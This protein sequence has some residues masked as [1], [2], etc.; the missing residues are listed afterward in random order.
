MARLIVEKGHEKGLTI[1]LPARTTTVFGRDMTANVQIKDTMASRSHFKIE[2]R[3]DGLWL[4]DL[5]SMNGTLL[6][7]HPAKESRLNSGD[8]IR[9]GETTYSFLP[10]DA[11]TDPLIGQKL[12]GYKLIERVG[13]G[14]MGTVYKAEQIDL[15]R[16]V[17][18]K[19]IS[20]EHL[21]NPEFVE[22]FVHEA[23]AAAKLNH[24]NIVQVYD[25]KKT[26]EL[27]YFSME[28]VPGGSVQDLLNNKR[29][30]PIPETVRMILEAARG[31][32][33]AHK[34]EIIHRDV[35]PD[36]FM[37]GEGNSI[38]IGDL[39][40]AQRLGEK[41]SADNE[42][43]VIGTPHY[44]AP[45]Q[46][47]GRPADVR[48]DVYSLGSTMYRM[49]A[50]F[51]PFQ[52]PS[53]RELVNKKAREEATPLHAALGGIPESLGK[54]CGKMMARLP[55]E[56]TQ[57]MTEVIA[58]LEAWTRAVAGGSAAPPEAPPVHRKL[59]ISAV[60]LLAIV[61]VG[62]V[63]AAGAMLKKND[64][65]PSDTAPVGPEVED[66]KAA[67]AKFDRA[68]AAKDRLVDGKPDEFDGVIRLYE[69]IIAR[70]PGTNYAKDAERH[71]AEIKKR[72]LGLMA[73]RGLK[74]L[75]DLDLETWKG[76]L[77]SFQAGREDVAEAD[78]RMREFRAFAED[79][80]WQGTESALAA[81][82]RAAA[83]AGWIGE[84]EKRRGDY[85]KLKAKTDKLMS[86][87][88]YRDAWEACNEYIADIAA[89]PASAKDR[90]TTLL[91]DLPARRLQQQVVEQASKHYDDAAA[92]AAEL[93]AKG[94]Y[95][96]AI[97]AL[98][99]SVRNSL[100]D[101]V[102]RAAKLSKEIHQRWSDANLKAE[103]H[104]KS[105]QRKLAD[106]DRRDFDAAARRWRE[107][108]L[109]FDPK[110][111]LADAQAIVRT[112]PDRFPRLPAAEAR[113]ASRIAPLK[114]LAEFKD[115][116]IQELNENPPGVPNRITLGKMTGSIVK[117]TDTHLTIT[118]GGSGAMEPSFDKLMSGPEQAGFLD[119]MRSAGK[120]AQPRWMMGVA[121]LCLELGYY[122]RAAED[123]KALEKSTDDAVRKFLAEM[124]PMADD[125]RYSDSDEIEAQKHFDRLAVALKD[126][127]GSPRHDIAR[128]LMI[129]RTRF[130]GTEFYLAQ[131]AKLD[132]IEKDR[133]EKDA[134]E[135]E[136]TVR[137]ER[138]RKIFAARA[139]VQSEARGREAEITRGLSQLKDPIE[140]SYSYGES[141]CGFG[142]VGPSTK[143]LLE[144][145]DLEFRRFP[146]PDKRDFSNPNS[147]MVWVARTG[148]SLMRNFHLQKQETRGLDIRTKIDA[149]FSDGPEFFPWTM[150]KTAHVEWSQAAADRVKKHGDKLAALEKELQENPDA[151]LVYELAEAHDVL[152][153]AVDAR[154]LYHALMTEYPD[155]EKVK[156]GEALHRSAEMAYLMRDVVEAEKLYLKVK[157]DYPAHP[158]VAQASAFDSVD[159]RLKS[160]NYLKNNMGLGK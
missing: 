115:L 78:K 17:A 118:L 36:N 9:V 32:E 132:E 158:K 88:G 42:D 41:L 82:R 125:W 73:A 94:E 85:E 151:K 99:A 83:L 56:R 67:E 53:V 129:L 55:E 76:L 155:H 134:K 26:N 153:S 50:G 108:I 136:K 75:E 131:K 111:A 46:V 29:K 105:E 123:L 127:P 93:E 80:S 97:E 49:I 14:G 1:P 63:I 152:R 146:T 90:Y 39:G 34:K 38:K 139:K 160:C 28:F 72:R 149:K 137:A 40:L 77:Q 37:I 60:A 66:P 107:Q 145:L 104:A 51:T 54:I 43:T 121:V 135:R 126:P 157:A 140:R 150:Y 117:A 102:D 92:R 91:F 6:N 148:G 19:I 69:E 142:N 71:A 58:E 79:P 31:L 110:P 59:L 52:A 109:R 106:L 147:V 159:N 112:T 22:L 57:T 21:K 68:T 128:T 116:M 154:G 15:Q 20:E 103:E 7:G 24:P 45:E 101:P 156:N 138:Y 113:L 3:A 70:W 143:A 48:S 89:F 5:Q 120:N 33:Y 47:L 35:K 2:P 13:R 100:K 65:K 10:E 87:A 61:V 86:E 144:A 4:V 96:K 119:W 44:I 23:R 8:L 95:A 114:A 98:E 130:G 25:V 124:K 11:G 16:I 27:Y 84:V 12:G 122:E 74:S 18:L 141:Q 62:G 30:I 64:G 133:L 81:G